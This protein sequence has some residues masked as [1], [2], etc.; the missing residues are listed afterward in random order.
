MTK[1]L[2]K[3]RAK[4][5]L[6]GPYLCEVHDIPDEYAK[7]YPF[8]NGDHVLMLGEIQQMPGHMAVALQDGR[9]VF[10]YHAEWFRRLTREE[11]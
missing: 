5:A 3:K 4:E 6:D 9:V 2:K 1:R 11:A 7:Y 8:K 10:G